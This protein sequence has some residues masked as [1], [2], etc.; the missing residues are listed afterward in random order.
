MNSPP[1]KP[2]NPFPEDKSENIEIENLTL[3]WNCSDP[4]NDSLKYYVFL[5]KEKK[6]DSLDLIIDDL[7]ESSY[8]TKIPENDT[9]YYWKIIA[10]NGEFRTE[11]DTWSFE[12]EHYFPD[13]WLIQDNPDFVYSFGIDKN[14]SQ[15]NSHNIAFEKAVDE[16]NIFIKTYLENLL[17]KFILE[18]NVTDPLSLNMKEKLIEVVSGKE[19]PDFFMS[20]QETIIINSK[21]YKTYVRIHIPK[22]TINKKLYEKII[23]AKKLF[24]ELQFSSSFQRFIKENA[25]DE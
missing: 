9:D 3:K 22:K 14:E 17:K 10:F 20:R 24:E 12:T 21:Y 2:S 23:L 18:A 1:D 13:W 5:G 11:S 15:I 8:K 25:K 6:L 7:K 16:K 19:Y 4:D